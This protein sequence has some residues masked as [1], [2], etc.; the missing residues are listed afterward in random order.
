MTQAYKDIILMPLIAS[1]SSAYWSI[2][3]AVRSN[4]T[5]LIFFFVS[6]WFG[7]E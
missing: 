5:V 2:L 1:D 6:F 4:R 7:G 3:K